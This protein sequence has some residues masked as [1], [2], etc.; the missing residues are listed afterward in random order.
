M[1]DEKVYTNDYNGL[2]IYAIAKDVSDHPLRILI[3]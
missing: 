1:T 2:S 3:S